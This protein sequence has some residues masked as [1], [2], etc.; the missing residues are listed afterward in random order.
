M[1]EAISKYYWGKLEREHGKYLPLLKR[2]FKDRNTTYNVTISPVR[3]INS[4]GHEKEYL[5]GKREELVEDA[6][7]KLACDGQD[8][9]VEQT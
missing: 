1:Y 3:M 7:R 9:S 8:K 5:P 2:Q 6:L 4:R